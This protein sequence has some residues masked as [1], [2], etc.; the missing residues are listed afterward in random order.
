FSP[1]W[2]NL[3]N[4]ISSFKVRVAACF[5][6]SDNFEGESICLSGNEKIDLFRLSNLSY[7]QHYVLNPLND[8][9]DSIKVPEDIQVTVYKDNDFSG[10]YFVLADDF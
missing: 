1:K 8:R 6:E 5:Y 7:D 3:N 9:V 4:S 2:S 10:D